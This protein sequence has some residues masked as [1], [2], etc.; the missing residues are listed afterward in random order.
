[1]ESAKITKKILNRWNNSC[2]WDGEISDHRSESLNIGEAAKAA[3]A[4]MARDA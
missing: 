3:L 4:I 2:I 1:M